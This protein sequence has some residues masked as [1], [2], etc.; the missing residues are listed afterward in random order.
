MRRITIILVSIAALA[1]A[2]SCN[3]SLSPDSA[4]DGF[5]RKT[6]HISAA[7]ILTNK[8][9][10]GEKEDGA[11]PMLWSSD[12]KVI[13]CVN[14]DP[15]LTQELSVIPLDGGKA[16][17]FGTL[18]LNLP[19]NGQ[20]EIFVSTNTTKESGG[21]KGTI[22]Y[23]PTENES[24]TPLG[25]SCDPS[26]II[27][28]A[29]KT[30]DSHAAVPADIK[31]DF[32]HSTA[33][34]KMTLSGI[35]LNGGEKIKYVEIQTPLGQNIG[36][37][38]TIGEEG[39][40][41]TSITLRGID[42]LSNPVWFAIAPAELNSSEALYVHVV[43]SEDRH[44]EKILNCSSRALEFKAGR[45][46][47]FTVNFSGIASAPRQVKTPRDLVLLKNAIQT[48]DYAFWMDGVVIKMANDLDY[49]G[50][51]VSGN[52]CTLPEGVTF[53]GQN[54]AIKNAVISDSIFRNVL[55]IVQNLK[56]EGGSNSLY[57]FDTV[58][59]T[60]KHIEIT[61]LTSTT[62]LITTNSGTID[63][64]TIDETS[65]YTCTWTQGDMGFVTLENTGLIKNS[66]VSADIAVADPERAAYNFGVFCPKCT[67]GQFVKCI[68]KSDVTIAT[69]T[70][71]NGCSL[72]GIVG[73]IESTQENSV[74]ILDQCENEGDLTL[75]LN[76]PASGLHRVCCAGG[77]AGGNF[78]GATSE[79]GVWKDKSYPSTGVIYNCANSGTIIMN[80]Y[81]PFNGKNGGSMGIALGGVIGAT[82]NDIN[83]CINRGSVIANL[84][85]DANTNTNYA[86]A[87]KIGG[88]VGAAHGKVLNCENKSS[89][90]IEMN[91]KVAQVH[92]ALYSGTGPVSN[93]CLGGVAGSVGCGGSSATDTEGAAANSNTAD[94]KISNCKNYSAN[95]TNS[96]ECYSYYKATQ[97]D[98]YNPVSYVASVCG[99]TV[100]SKS[101]NEDLGNTGL[102]VINPE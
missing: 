30:Y 71:V 83:G 76:L 13:I 91:G 73:V 6:V 4:P 70:A 69:S 77:I 101:G 54:H 22:K 75:T 37:S 88:I 48:D 18:D 29:S 44:F 35:S 38:V 59:G 10:F 41:H 24:Q 1:F 17:D 23:K 86:G 47:K 25:N 50:T 28:Y 27:I 60:V 49:N 51:A 57:L 20:V 12:D 8:A 56:I 15:D 67:A 43:T 100:A 58:S 89:A 85:N 81:S 46:S 7:E 34:G 64:L 9:A 94:S 16:A 92:N 90:V 36:G 63:E 40:S 78:K 93:P 82:I 19:Q 2:A 84:N 79:T 65:S 52:S 32:D 3:K 53:D 11:Y 80:Y 96:A 72:G 26:S 42:D 97:T 5:I 98:Y 95:I 14:N 21:R 61:G 99:W 66:E 68:N 55:G 62:P 33:Y 31:L 102:P 39:A 74:N 87:P 45:V